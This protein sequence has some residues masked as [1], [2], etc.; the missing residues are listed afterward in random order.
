MHPQPSMTAPRREAVTQRIL[1]ARL[2]KIKELRNEVA[3]VTRRLEAM[4]L[5]NQ[6]LRQMQYRHLK[7]LGRYEHSQHHLPQVVARHQSEV[8]HL[9]QLLKN[10]QGK[11]R[12]MTRKLREMDQELLKTK[13]VL[14]Q[15]QRLS[16]DKNLAERE[17]LTQKLSMLT[18]RLEGNDK[19]IQVGA[20]GALQGGRW[21]C[22]LQP[23][24]IYPQ[25]P[26]GSPKA[27]VRVQSRTRLHN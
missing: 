13:D 16:E 26:L 3:D 22:M 2:N 17:E 12:T 10:S 5:E 24:W 7:A 25:H 19:K 20:R 11:E 23:T 1:S 6:F 4:A 27:A 21:P 8:Q 18:A 15:L 14:Q 9:R